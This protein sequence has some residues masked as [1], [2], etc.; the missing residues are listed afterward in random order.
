M[1][2]AQTPKGLPRTLHLL[3]GFRDFFPK[4]R[5]DTICVNWYT[6]F[7]KTPRINTR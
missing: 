5:F 1:I 2:K 7:A 4:T 3:R 6:T